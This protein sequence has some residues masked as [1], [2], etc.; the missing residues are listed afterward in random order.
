MRLCAIPLPS[1]SS[2]LFSFFFLPYLAK[3]QSM[4]SPFRSTTVVSYQSPS[5]PI[6][7]G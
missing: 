3:I 6:F 2:S 1:F 5:S 7:V 4:A